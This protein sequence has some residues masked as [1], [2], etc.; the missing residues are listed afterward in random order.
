MKDLIVNRLYPFT[1][2]IVMLSALSGCIEFPAFSVPMD[3][4]VQ[5]VDM[6]IVD[7]KIIDQK[8]EDMAVID[9]K[10]PIDQ[11]IDQ[12]I[13]MAPVVD[14]M[15]IEDAEIVDMLIVDMMLPTDICNEGINPNCPCRTTACPNTQWVHINEGETKLKYHDP[16]EAIVLYDTSIDYDFWITKT[17]ITVQQFQQC[18]DE[19]LNS[20]VKYCLACDLS[21]PVEQRPK[22]C[23]NLSNDKV[24]TVNDLKFPGLFTGTR[25]KTAKLWQSIPTQGINK[26]EPPLVNNPNK[27]ITGIN[28]FQAS[29]YCQWIGGKLPSES[30][31]HLSALGTK[32]QNG[33]IRTYPWLG[34]QIGC[35]YAN[36]LQIKTVTIDDSCMLPNQLL[37]VCSKSDGNTPEGLCDMLGNAEEWVQD[38]LIFSQAQQNAT[39]GAPNCLTPDCQLIDIAMPMTKKITKGFGFNSPLDLTAI[40]GN[41]SFVSLDIKTVSYQA[42]A[43]LS[44][45][46]FRC[47]FKR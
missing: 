15:V 28:W 33:H 23:I 3:M 1:L 10:L 31:W 25:P 39:N 41:Q 27:P 44:S 17:E 16:P 11:A 14:M 4:Q 34:D 29:Q 21:V 37:D 24:G 19:S 18:I 2:S 40:A 26:D 13:D 42:D 43:V 47:V 36:L 8:I 45:L 7:M 12:A 38:D 5:Q 30:E 9:E 6:V 32:Q 22:F 20:E 35:G 46:G